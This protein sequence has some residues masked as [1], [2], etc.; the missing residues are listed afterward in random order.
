MSKRQSTTERPMG[1][2]PQKLTP[3]IAMMPLMPVAGEERSGPPPQRP[4]PSRADSVRAAQAKII[5]R[6]SLRKQ[7]AAQ[8]TD[9]DS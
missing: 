8:C 1:V 2:Q 3:G 5:R 7:R 4:E 9:R 6:K